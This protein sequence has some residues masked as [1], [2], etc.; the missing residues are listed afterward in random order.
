M[1]KYK[2]LGII[3][4]FLGIFGSWFVLSFLLKILPNLKGL[5][6]KFG[7]SSQNLAPSYL[8][9]AF[10][11]GAAVINVF[12]GVKNLFGGQKNKDKYFKWG[13][14]AIAIIILLSAFSSAIF[15]L[16]TI[17]PLYDLTY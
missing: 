6:A 3:N 12:L 11:G 13:I 1:N 17:G 5:H 4:F 8:A 7:L 16:N 2:I 15:S 14:W 10:L 9:M